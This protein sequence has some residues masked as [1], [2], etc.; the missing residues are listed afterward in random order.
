MPLAKSFWSL[1]FGILTNDFGL[2]RMVSVAERRDNAST[3]QVA[4]TAWLKALSRFADR[5]FVVLAAF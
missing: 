2:G 4:L 3:A 1:K 5:D